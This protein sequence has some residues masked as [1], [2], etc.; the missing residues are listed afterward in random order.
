VSIKNTIKEK[1]FENREFMCKKRQIITLSISIALL[2]VFTI[3]RLGFG[4]FPVIIHS[5]LLA[6]LITSLLYLRYINF[7]H[8]V[9]K[10]LLGLMT[11]GFVT[12]FNQDDNDDGKENAIMKMLTEYEKEYHETKKGSF[13]PFLW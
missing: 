2:L 5:L 7:K 12:T 9:V 11:I 1:W 8:S 4:L 10:I 6:G 3:L 13:L